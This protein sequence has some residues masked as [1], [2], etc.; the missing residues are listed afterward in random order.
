MNNLR[1]FPCAPWVGVLV[2]TLLTACKEQPAHL[3][4]TPQPIIANNQIRFSSG[5][6]QLALLQT[7]A[8]MPGQDLAVELPAKLVW[9][10][11]KTQRIYPAFSG[12]VTHIKADVGQ[13]VGA[14]SVLAH[15]ASPDFGVAQADAAKA[16]AYYDV[17]Q[18]NARRQQELLDAGIIARKDW[19]QAQADAQ[20]ASAEWQRAVS[21]TRLYGGSADVNQ[22][23]SL[24][25]SIA[26]TVVE[27]NLNPGQEVRPDLSGPGI[28]PLFVVTNPSH[29]WALIDAREYDLLSLKAG[30]M[31]ELV[32]AS[33][34]NMAFPARVVTASDA[35]DPITRTIKVR[36]SVDNANKLLKGEM[37]ATAKFSRPMAGNLVIPSSS[38]FL[39]GTSNYVFVQ[40]AAGVF[41]PRTIK[42]SHEGPQQVYVAEGLKSGELVVT[43]NGL[44]LE[45]ELRNAQEEAQQSPLIQP[46]A[47]P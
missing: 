17:T 40:V 9:N 28:P 8:A 14:G 21:R 6:P 22:E 2:L 47:K 18:K 45:R 29:L 39:R 32:V 3:M 25:S 44:L 13:T 23:L 37:L 38:V 19:E 41:E 20:A 31:L 26:G 34:P 27:R 24:T 30:T 42:L 33:L 16:K 46:K 11:E 5:H 7:T 35:I 10:E 15:I 4:I 43:Q 1:L 12:R 36:A